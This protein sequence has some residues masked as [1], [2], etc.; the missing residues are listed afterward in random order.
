MIEKYESEEA[1]SE[2][3]RGA[4]RA[5]LLSALDPRRFTH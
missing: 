5:D 3:S 1:L 2:H 4:A